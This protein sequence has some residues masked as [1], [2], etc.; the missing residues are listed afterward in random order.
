MRLG[1]VLVA[2]VGALLPGGGTAQGAPQCELQMA[3]E[4]PHEG[5]TFSAGAPLEVEGW[6]VDRAAESGTGVLSVQAA[7]DVPR[8]QGGTA[9]VAV[10]A[11]ERADVARLLGDEHY[12]YS[13]Y[14][15]DLPTA[16]LETGLHT[17]YVTI[18]T[19]CG[20]H[21]EARG[22]A[23]LPSADSIARVLVP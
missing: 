10:H 17:L 9:Y 7:L 20:W 3:L 14:R 21:T 18:L 2:L 6:A 19:H 15:V 12:L 5:A 11:A 13:G 4:Y 22:V 23:I 16:D 1:L 8:E